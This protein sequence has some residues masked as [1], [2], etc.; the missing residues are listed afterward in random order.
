MRVTEGR[1]TTQFEPGTTYG[2]GDE[3]KE[4]NDKAAKEEQKR[5]DEIKE[6]DEIPLKFLRE[7]VATDDK[8]L[9]AIDLKIKAAKILLE[10]SVAER[11]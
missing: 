2:Y 10:Y 7:F 8:S 1:P 6:K 9:M 5:K 11:Y 4:R 3:V